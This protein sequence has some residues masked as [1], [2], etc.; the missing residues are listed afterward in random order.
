MSEYVYRSAVDYQPEERESTDKLDH[1]GTLHEE[2]IRC[3]DC[4]YYTH[5]SWH[6]CDL[7]GIAHEVKSDGFCAWGEKV[8]E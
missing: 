3:R 7:R 6:R 1:Y 8:N 5:S 2:I 4:R